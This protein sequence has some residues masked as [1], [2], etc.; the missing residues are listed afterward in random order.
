[1]T[2]CVTLLSTGPPSTTGWVWAHSLKFPSGSVQLA[3]QPP[4]PC[5]TG[6]S[7]RSCATVHWPQVFLHVA[8]STLHFAQSN[9]FP[10]AAFIWF[11]H[12]WSA[13]V[14]VGL[15][16]IVVHDAVPVVISLFGHFRM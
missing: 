1:M 14:T 10:Y 8:P 12:S 15:R 6:Q 11:A 5:W 13:A 9:D 2:P 16:P 3:T 7:G 4:A